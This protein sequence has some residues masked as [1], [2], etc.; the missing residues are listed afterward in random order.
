[1]AA[2]DRIT[3]TLLKKGSNVGV[4]IR[5]GYRLVLAHGHPRA[6]LPHGYVFEHVLVVERVLGY[7]LDKR[8]QIHHVNGNGLDNHPR[9]LVVC[10]DQR[11]H[12]LLHQRTTAYRETGRADFRCCAF[13]RHYDDPAQMVRYGTK[14]Q[15]AHR[16]CIN[17][18]GRA[19]RIKNIKAARQYGREY[20]RRWR[21][22]HPQRWA[23]IQ[24]ATY[25]RRKAR[26]IT[27]DRR[28]SH[29]EPQKSEGSVE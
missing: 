7:C 1:M 18:D 11:Y 22:A 29:S 3:P 20:L 13:C 2:R 4:I 8:H 27:A 5:N 26:T 17:A 16:D 19:R 9:N 10:E 23:E 6:Q 25:L 28:D 12:A 14:R 15:V 21:A 24:H